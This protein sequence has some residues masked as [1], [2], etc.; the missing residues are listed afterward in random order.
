MRVQIELMQIELR[1]VISSL[2]EMSTVYNGLQIDPQ[3][4]LIAH[5]NYWQTSSAHSV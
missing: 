2:E 4:K 3:T 5:L 1:I